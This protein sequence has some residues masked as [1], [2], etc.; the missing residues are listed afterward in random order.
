MINK[1]NYYILVLLIEFGEKMKIFKNRGSIYIPKSNL[2]NDKEQKF[3][4]CALGVIL[5]MTLVFLIIFG[6][7][8]NFSLKE[9][10]R[11]D[12]LKIATSDEIEKLPEV[13][14]KTN[15]IL[16]ETADD[17]PIV[18]FAVLAQFD[19]DTKTYKASVIGKDILLDGSTMSEFYD[20]GG[21]ANVANAVG[22]V[23][24]IEFD[25]YFCFGDKD[26]VTMFE[27]L[28]T[29]VYAFTDNIKDEKKGDDGFTVRMKSGEQ[30]VSGSKALR[31]LRYYCEL[32][33]DYTTAN[34]FAVSCMNEFF[35]E[36]FFNERQ[37]IFSEIVN[38][39]KTDMTVKDYTAFE[40]ALTV[41]CSEQTS[42]NVYY[43]ELSVSE[44]RFTD[45][46]VQKIKSCFV[47]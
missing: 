24:G 25:N 21:P 13:S 34:N 45:E 9:F 1:K 15:F 12:E 30:K 36:K 4:F 3:L 19:M 31:L 10:F 6:V 22:A 27:E 20:D 14:G 17:E 2:K 32:K 44:N 37:S 41:I 8:Y 28:G 33:N 39:A 23:F 29:P 46:S 5:A 18:H 16:I 43:P 7:K 26:F 42:M 11:P 40:N 35:N 47:K 38:I